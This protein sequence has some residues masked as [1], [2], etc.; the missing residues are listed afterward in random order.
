MAASAFSPMPCRP[1]LAGA[2]PSPPPSYTLHAAVPK[3]AAPA[4]PSVDCGSVTS[5]PV[6]NFSQQQQG[7]LVSQHQ[8]TEPTRP[9]GDTDNRAIWP[10][11][12]A[13]ETLTSTQLVLVTV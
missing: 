9:N 3:S 1:I 4:L 2:A 10:Y 5:P 12:R 8:R 13:Q 11:G 6:R 7:R